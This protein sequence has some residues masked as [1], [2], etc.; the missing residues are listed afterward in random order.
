[1]VY[2]L[3]LYIRIEMTKKKSGMVLINRG[4]QNWQKR[5]LMYKNLL[6]RFINKNNIYYKSQYKNN[7]QKYINKNLF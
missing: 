5:R 4:A 7:S 1:M 6:K 3:N 2:I